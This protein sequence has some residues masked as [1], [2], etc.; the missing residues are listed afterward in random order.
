MCTDNA[1]ILLLLLWLGVLAEPGIS[2]SGVWCLAAV[3][4]GAESCSRPGY[5]GNWTSGV[6]LQW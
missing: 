1:L 6:A 3:V 2:F 4:A 5:G